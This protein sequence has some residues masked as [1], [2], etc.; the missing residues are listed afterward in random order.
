[1]WEACV[2]QGVCVATG[3]GTPK[4]RGP[5]FQRAGQAHVFVFKELK[6]GDGVEKTVTRPIGQLFP[7]QGRNC[8][9]AQ[10]EPE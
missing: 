4:T 3:P 10:E 1:M 8:S 7:L 6:E 9:V 2:L 5:G